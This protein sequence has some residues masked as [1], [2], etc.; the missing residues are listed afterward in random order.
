MVR[1]PSSRSVLVDCCRLLNPAER[2]DTLDLRDPRPGIADL[3]RTIRQTAKDAWNKLLY[4]RQN[5]RMKRFKHNPKSLVRKLRRA[6]TILIICHGNIIRS[7]F[8]AHFLVQSVMNKKSVSIHSAGLEA[9]PGLRAHPNAVSRAK[10]LG[11]DLS[12]HVSIP[13]TEDMVRRVDLVFVME[14]AHLLLMNKRFS[15]FWRKTFLLGCFAQEAPLEISDPVYK[16]E[17][18]FDMCFE[19]IIRSVKAIALVLREGNSVQR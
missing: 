13:L 4:L 17:T 15:G 3:D 1:F 19:Q 10:S 16:D 8:A 12:A 9:V 7:P 2:W 5:R 11:F 14:V 6:R 18:I